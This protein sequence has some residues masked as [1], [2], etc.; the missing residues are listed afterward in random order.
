MKTSKFI[1][2]SLTCFIALIILVA[3]ISVR[4]T[5]IK[6]DEFSNNLKVERTDLA[7]ISVLYIT[8]CHNISIIESDSSYI[9]VSTLKD[10]PFLKIN[11]T[12]HGDTLRI[13]DVKKPESL[14]FVTVHV[15]K[16]LKT[17]NMSNSVISVTRVKS[18]NISLVLE[19]SKLNFMLS[20][21]D[22][23]SIANMKVV[24]KNH[25]TVTVNS[26]YIDSVSLI[27][28]NSIADLNLSPKFIRGM[29][30]DRS[31]LLTQQPGEISVKRDSTSN[32]IINS[33]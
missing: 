2:I 32:I 29:L 30:S 7:A 26:M 25:S 33:Y 22:K 24:A 15:A 19:N 12:L 18:E 8:D 3:T 20:K 17:I 13:K 10:Q 28:Q 6:T 4:I 1:F 23:T 31:K 9:K 27:L 21:S 14:V 16:G 5:G 11:Y